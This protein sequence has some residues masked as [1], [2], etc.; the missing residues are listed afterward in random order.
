MRDA[1]FFGRLD[2]S[3]PHR[4]MMAIIRQFVERPGAKNSQSNPI[5][6]ECSRQ[7]GNYK[8]RHDI[9]GVYDVDDFLDVSKNNPAL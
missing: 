4:K 1:D 6:Q 3:Q 2:V 8:I 7:D 9:A 5:H